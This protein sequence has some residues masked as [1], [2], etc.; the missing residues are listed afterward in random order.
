MYI[1]VHSEA[2]P[3]VG[4]SKPV[5]WRAD[6]TYAAI[7]AKVGGWEGGE[8]LMIFQVLITSLGK[9][10]ILGHKKRFVSETRVQSRALL[11]ALTLKIKK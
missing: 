7:V 11:Y 8:I 9:K 3:L 2:D 1:C 10:C 6:A 4:W 5:E